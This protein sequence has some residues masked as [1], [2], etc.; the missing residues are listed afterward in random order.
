MRRLDFLAAAQAR[1]IFRSANPS[2]LFEAPAE[3]VR[4]C[5]FMQSR[6]GV[7]V[8]RRNGQGQ[9]SLLLGEQLDSDPVG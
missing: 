2:Y 5:L 9:G 6:L 7:A 4:L 3:V 1:S 8:C